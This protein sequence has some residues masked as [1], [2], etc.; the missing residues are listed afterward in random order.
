MKDIKLPDSFYL[1]LPYLAL[2]ILLTACQIIEIKKEAELIESAGIIEGRVVN[3][4]SQK[5]PVIVKRY[6]KKGGVYLNDSQQIANRSGQYRFTTLPGTYFIAAFVDVNHDN[7]FHQHNENSEY[8]AFDNGKPARIIVTAKNT[9][10]VQPFTIKENPQYF[11]SLVEAREKLEKIESNL[12]RQIGWDNPI[13][14]EKYYSLGLW[15]PVQFLE[16][17]GGGLFFLKEFHKEKIPIV[18]IHGI[19][20]GPLNWKNT[21]AQ[22]DHNVFQPWLFYYPSGLRLDMISDYLLEAI[23]ILDAHN[24]FDEFG[25]VAHS[26]GGLIARSFVKKCVKQ[27]PQLAGKL[28]LVVTI[29]SPMNGMDSAASGVKHSPF[30]IPSWRDVA[31]DSH[32]IKDLI[33]W[34]WPKNIPYHLIFSYRVNSSDDGVVDLNSQIPLKLQSEATRIYGFNNNHTG[35][36]KD[37]EFLVLLNS[38]FSASL[39]PN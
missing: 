23:S 25:I 10:K 39:L 8:F 32:Y 6:F 33:S 3:G 30:V 19:N 12:G 7:E 26:M 21:I 11:A 18:F 36:L 14:N 24:D 37:K 13:L 20:G 38:I 35:T 16:K 31:S 22:I 29:N 15:K 34:N 27:F 1:I 2:I 4:S 28:N 5:G 17:I 9:T